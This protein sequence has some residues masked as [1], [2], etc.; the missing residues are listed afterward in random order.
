M[1]N[2]PGLLAIVASRVLTM[3][4]ANLIMNSGIDG[5]EKLQKPKAGGQKKLQARKQ[6]LAS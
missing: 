2:Y 5:K 1:I 6:A 4:D 3:A